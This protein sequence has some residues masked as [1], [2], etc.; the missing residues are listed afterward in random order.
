V[1]R[2]AVRTTTDATSAQSSTG[3]RIVPLR[4]A[5]RHVA[6]GDVRSGHG[7]G[8]APMISRQVR[9]IVSSPRPPVPESLG[10]AVIGRISGS[11]AHPM[12]YAAGSH[13]RR[14]CAVRGEH[15]NLGGAR[16]DGSAY[17]HGQT[18]VLQRDLNR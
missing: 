3:R 11:A 4:D 5:G 12:S 9:S 1:V 7:F 18:L 17:E 8:A 2:A 13:E 16:M 10:L 6:T 15:Y 14:K